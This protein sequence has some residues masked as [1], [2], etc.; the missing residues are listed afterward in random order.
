MLVTKSVYSVL[1]HI[2][3]RPDSHYEHYVPT[4][5]STYSGLSP[6]SSSF[7]SSSVIRPSQIL[8]PEPILHARLALVGN[9]V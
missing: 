8:T 6:L 5:M 4:Y 7:N 2:H 9:K 3:P 1:Y